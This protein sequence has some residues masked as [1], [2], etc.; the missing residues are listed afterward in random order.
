VRFENDFGESE[1]FPIG[2]FDSNQQP[3]PSDAYLV[4]L[5]QFAKLLLLFEVTQVGAAGAID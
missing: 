3:A 5:D 4:L 2:K 1:W